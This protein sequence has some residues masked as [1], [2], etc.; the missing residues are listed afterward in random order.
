MATTPW[1]LQ[2]VPVN[3]T[4]ISGETDASYAFKHIVSLEKCQQYTAIA[5]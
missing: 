2:A 3:T 1:H 5:I 4:Y